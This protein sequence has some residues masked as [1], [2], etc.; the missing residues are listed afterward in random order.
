MKTIHRIQTAGTARL[1]RCAAGDDFFQR[2][3]AS[4]PGSDPVQWYL[5]EFGHII[6]SD[7]AKLAF[8]RDGYDPAD[9]ESVRKF[10]APASALVGQLIDAMFERTAAGNYLCLTAGGNGSGK[11]TF[12]DGIRPLLGDAW[13]IDATMGSFEPARVTIARA[14][15]LGMKPVVFWIRRP[16]EEA[17]NNGVLKRAA[18]GSHATPRDIFEFTHAQVPLN[19]AKLRK[20]FSPSLLPVIEIENGQALARGK[21]AKK[22]SL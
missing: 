3:P 6:N 8:L 11:S 20:E 7:C 14:L 19:L 9:P 13:C 4:G 12:C 15:E 2:H 16:P 17:W 22:G 5:G 21:S 1:R 10:H 18:H